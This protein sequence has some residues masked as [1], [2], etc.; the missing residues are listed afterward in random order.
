MRDTRI[1]FPLVS[2]ACAA[3]LAVFGCG[4][5]SGS[6]PSAAQN[7]VCSVTKTTNS[8]TVKTFVDGASVTIET[9]ESLAGHG[10]IVHQVKLPME[11]DSHIQRIANYQAKAD[12]NSGIKSKSVSRVSVTYRDASE[13]ATLNGIPEHF[14]GFLDP[15]IKYKA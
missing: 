7:D 9:D 10:F 15:Y 1:A 12:E 4:G 14:F 11:F 2:L 6:G 8:V 5:D 3:G 13:G